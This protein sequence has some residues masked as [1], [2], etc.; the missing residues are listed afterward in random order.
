M[1]DLEMPIYRVTV[2]VTVT[3]PAE[4]RY[5]AISGSYDL[6][7]DA[8]VES[9]MSGDDLQVTGLDEVVLLV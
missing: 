3:M 2:L 9:G 8:L 1:S 6:V 7:S 5:Q 4:N